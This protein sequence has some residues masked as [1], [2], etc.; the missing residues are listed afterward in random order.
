MPLHDLVPNLPDTM[1][2]SADHI[3]T[4]AGLLR[5]HN[6]GALPLL[7]A[8]EVLH[9]AGAELTGGK[10]GPAMVLAASAIEMLVGELLRQAGPLL[11]WTT[12]QQS[13]AENAPF[14]S[15]VEHHLS[16]ALGCTIKVDDRD[17]AWGAW[18][19]EAYGLRNRFV[20]QG[21]RPSRPEAEQAWAS[22]PELITELQRAVAQVPELTQLADQFAVFHLQPPSA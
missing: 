10:P 3:E 1:H 7:P 18:W 17:T 11:A 5:T 8:F 22:I 4:A 9:E 14:R 21:L 2:V 6:S 20:H 15:R 13:K 19:A 12:A 16:T